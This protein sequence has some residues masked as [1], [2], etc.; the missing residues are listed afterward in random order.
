[1]AWAR[2]S[3][4][5]R[6]RSSAATRPGSGIDQVAEHVQVLEPS[7]SAV[8]SVTATKPMPA[9]GPAARCASDTPS[10]VS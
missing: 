2:C 1:M 10:V 4:S 6:E 5:C 9:G 7:N 8:T 3:R